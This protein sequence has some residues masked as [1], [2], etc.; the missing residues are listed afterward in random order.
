MTIRAGYFP[1]RPGFNPYQALFA[2]ALERAGVSVERIAPRKFFPLHAVLRR[3][4]DL[5]HLDWPDSLFVGRSALAT[6]AK[7]RMYLAGLRKLR[8]FPLVWTAHNLIGH[9]AANAD[10]RRRMVQLLVDRCNAIVVMSHAAERL[11]RESCRIGDSTRVAVIPHGHYI[12]TYANVVGRPQARAAFSVDESARVVLF[13]G[14]LQPYKGLEDL[15]DAFARIAREGDLLV[16]A[17]PGGGAEYCEQVRLRASAARPQ[18]C[19]IRVIPG[20][21]PDDLLQ[22]Y[23]NAAD[24]VALPFKA[25][26]NSGSALLA[27]SFGRCVIA[28]ALGSLP[29]VLCDDGFFGYDPAEPDALVRTLG[30]ALERSDLVDRGLIARDYLRRHYDWTDIGRKVRELYETILK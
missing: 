5:L 3:P 12:D 25:I 22:L 4:I 29:E 17:G 30:A 26:L 10:Y 6:W 1:F 18:G 19:E 28:P 7:R 14:R 15:I 9:D 23:F 21:I 2:S 24:V 13:L 16:L 27:Q 11:L 20:L 8:N